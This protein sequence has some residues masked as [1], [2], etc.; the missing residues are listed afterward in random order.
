MLLRR[1]SAC[2]RCLVNPNQL[3]IY[4][5]LWLNGSRHTGLL[6]VLQSA[7]SSGT[8]SYFG[9]FVYANALGDGYIAQSNLPYNLFQVFP[10]SVSFPV[11]S[12]NNEYFYNIVKVEH[13]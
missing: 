6:R 5:C 1:H 10:F 13:R 4:N 8:S 7:C 12:G 11:F 9:S 2:S 3:C